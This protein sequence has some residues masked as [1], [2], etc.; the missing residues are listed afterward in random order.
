MAL[1]NQ[2][3]LPLYI[4]DVLTDEKLVECTA[5]S[6]GVYFLLL[7]ILHK[8]ESYGLLCLKQKYKQNKSK[9]SEFASMLVKQMPF[10]EETIY[11][12]LVELVKEKVLIIDED[13][14]Y[15]KR[16]VKDGELSI[17]RS[18]I[19]KKGGS[20]V[21]KQYGKKGFL[22]FMS[23]GYEKNKIGI[24]VNPQARL[25]RL[26][27]DLKLPKYFDI[28][29][30]VEVSDMGKSE[31]FAHQFFGNLM[32]GEWVK[33]NFK[34]SKEKFDLLKAKLKAKTEAN[35]EYETEIKNEDVLVV[36]DVV[37]KEKKTQKKFI[38][39]TID[40]IQSFAESEMNGSKDAPD[41][42]FNYYEARGWMMQK[43][44]MKNWKAAYKNWT[45]NEKQYEAVKGTNQHRAETKTEQNDRLYRDFGK[46]L[47]GGK[48]LPDIFELCR[49]SEI[50][51]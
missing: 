45:K 48:P 49:D 13:T 15:Q 47:T 44:P 31:D 26:R 20:N 40:E 24:S 27:S 8:Q 3:Y 11:N 18:E 50:K 2:P 37:K 10:T 23:D 36:E 42:F 22:Y 33:S 32:N 41:N 30:A 39:P 4:Q 21:T 7:C 12:A 34:I 17:V 38:A 51:R 28:V 25:Y 5:E 1:R 9:E 29:D 19:G 43:T 35:T 46:E 16:M 14:L 6:H